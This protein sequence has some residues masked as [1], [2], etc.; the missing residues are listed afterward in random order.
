MSRQ[1]EALEKHVKSIF[2]KLRLV[3]IDR[4]GSILRGGDGL[5]TSAI[6]PFRQQRHASTIYLQ[7]FEAAKCAQAPRGEDDWVCLVG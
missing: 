5:L 1:G 6:H 3:K 7:Y 2:G 4:F